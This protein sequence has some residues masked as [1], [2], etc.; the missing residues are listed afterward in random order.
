MPNLGNGVS[1]LDDIEKNQ[2]AWTSIK[3]KNLV[4]K[5]KYS[6]VYDSKNLHPWK[7]VIKK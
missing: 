2:Y 3:D 1:T 5:D 4:N 6:I 7:L